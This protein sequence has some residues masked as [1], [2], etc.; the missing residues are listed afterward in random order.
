MSSSFSPCVSTMTAMS[1]NTWW[2]SRRLRST[3]HAASRRSW[4]SCTAASTA[5]LPC[6]ATAA[7]MSSS[8]RPSEMMRSITSSSGTSPVS[9]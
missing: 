8:P 5:P 7:P 9:V 4:I 2:S 1:R 3:S 6:S